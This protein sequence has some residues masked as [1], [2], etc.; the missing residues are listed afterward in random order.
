MLCRAWFIVSCCLFCGICGLAFSL[1]G[2]GLG[3]Y[4]LFVTGVVCLIDHVVVS[5]F[6]FVFGGCLRLFLF[7]D[8]VFVL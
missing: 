7:A 4:G 1:F 2:V 6:R 8:G 3:V 5:G